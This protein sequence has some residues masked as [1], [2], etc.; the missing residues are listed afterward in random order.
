MLPL[1]VVAVVVVA[2][3]RALSL[4]S[5][6]TWTPSWQWHCRCVERVCH[7]VACVFG[8]AVTKLLGFV[9]GALMTQG[10]VGVETQPIMAAE[11]HNQPF[12][13]CTRLSVVFPFILAFRCPWRRSV[14]ARLLPLLQTAAHHQLLTALQ[15]AARQGA[16]RLLLLGLRPGLQVVM[17]QTW[18]WMRTQCCSGP[19]Q[20]PW[21]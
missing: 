19:W 1:V 17:L 5:T 2:A 10:C 8:N 9:S 20:C 15:Q 3:A 18:I 21:R 14:L 12:C 11:T 13:A 16:Q 6:P 7:F 4:V